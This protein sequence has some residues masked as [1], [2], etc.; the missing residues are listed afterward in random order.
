MIMQRRYEIISIPHDFSAYQCASSWACPHTVA[1]LNLK[2]HGI[3]EGSLA[4][5]LWFR[6]LIT[7]IPFLLGDPEGSHSKIVIKV[8]YVKSMGIKCDDHGTALLSKHMIIS[9]L[10][11]LRLYLHVQCQFVAHT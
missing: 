9:Y 10:R 11:S 4:P 3:P 2:N 6:S 7:V 8:Y 5:T 1:V